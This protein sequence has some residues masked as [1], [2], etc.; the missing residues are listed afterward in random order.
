[1]PS[2]ETSEV[3]PTA[4][5][6]AAPAG[7]LAASAAA[8][9]AKMQPNLIIAPLPVWRY[10]ASLFAGPPQ[11]GRRGLCA[12]ADRFVSE[13]RSPIRRAECTPPAPGLALRKRRAPPAPAR[14]A[15]RTRPHA[16]RAPA[17]AR[18]APRA[19]RAAA[20]G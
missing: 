18:S 9:N 11:V 15:G 19:A 16:R 6:P 7:E 8:S 4:S 13:P 5:A 20:A 2:L 10:K 12:Q 14:R 1:M 3:E 17:H